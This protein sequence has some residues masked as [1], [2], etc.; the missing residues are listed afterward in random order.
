MAET[1]TLPRPGTA[2][3]LKPAESPR[4]A[5]PEIV[6]PKDPVAVHAAEV[7]EGAQK[8]GEDPALTLEVIARMPDEAKPLET[9]I[10]GESAQARAAVTSELGTGAEDPRSDREAARQALEAKKLDPDRS[11]HLLSFDGE[12]VQQHAAYLRSLRDPSVVGPR[13]YGRSVVNG[14]HHKGETTHEAEEAQETATQRYQEKIEAGVADP[15]M[16]GT[17]MNQK[18]GVQ[19]EIT[20]PPSTYEEA[21]LRI[22]QE[23]QGF[24]EKGF[25]DA[26]QAA[27]I[28]TEATSFQAMYQT[29][30]QEA[31]PTKV[32]EA[33][34]DLTRMIVYQTR[35]DKNVLVGSDHGERHIIRGNM[36][37]ADQV[38]SSLEGLGVLVSAKDRVLVH[39]IITMHDLGYT[40]GAAQASGGFDASKDHP[41]AGSEFIEANRGWIVD[42]FG[43]ESF[44]V[45]QG[46]ILNHSYVG[47]GFETP[48]PEGSDINPELIRAITSAVDSLGVTAETKVPS[49]F[50]NPDTVAEL[51]KIRLAGR[52]AQRDENGDFV[53][54]KEK[55]RY[56]EVLVKRKETL[57]GLAV[58]SPNEQSQ[59]AY[60]SAVESVNSKTADVLGQ[61]TGEVTDVQMVRH[62]ENGQLVPQVNME[63][64]D[65][66]GTQMREMFG[67]SAELAQFAKAM[68]D[69][70]MTSDQIQNFHA[71]IEE[72]RKK[73][74]SPSPEDLRFTSEKAIVQVG[75]R[76]HISE[77]FAQIREVVSEASAVTHEW[78]VV[79][80]L[81]GM[82]VGQEIS[83]EKMS[84]IVRSLR[85]LANR[86]PIGDILQD[87]VVIDQMQSSDLAIRRHVISRIQSVLQA[88]I[89]SYM[90]G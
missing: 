9:A 58:K 56:D 33:T 57:R 83:S 59:Q 49:F 79:E 10:A 17:E 89:D 7:I 77:E 36:K 26:E 61:F 81:K 72:A 23:L 39:A 1:A 74:I 29:G 44:P 13:A 11:R 50:K 70:G 62:S 82:S 86:K 43:E 25:I 15:A 52:M 64:I 73:G 88:D 84:G 20:D 54:E 38:L 85:L 8:A 45:I 6:K 18:L 68:E 2:E 60:L 22:T 3:P 53:S 4:P 87:E 55:A 16:I 48:R 28:Q 35:M 21:A 75:S 51:F 12:E 41:V 47:G 63:I 31:D 90:L 34:R 65:E 66:V 5:A 24:V 46:A 14:C 78:R 69:L 30:Y 42:K 40:N 76:E 27:V 80:R 71:V 37:F 67:G 32:F 19:T